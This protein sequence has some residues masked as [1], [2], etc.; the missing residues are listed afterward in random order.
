MRE[1]E[2]VLGAIAVSS[3]TRAQGI[4]ADLKTDTLAQA[5]LHRVE[6]GP[7]GAIGRT[8]HQASVGAPDDAFLAAISQAAESRT[9]PRKSRESRQTRETASAYNGS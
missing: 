4:I 8:L 1:V 9:D 2:S 3:D 6:L 5:I 7:F